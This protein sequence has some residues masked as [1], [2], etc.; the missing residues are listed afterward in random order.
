MKSSQYKQLGKL[1][2]PL[3]KICYF[4]PRFTLRNPIEEGVL[5]AQSKGYEVAIIVYK[6]KE[7]TKWIQ[8][9]GHDEMD[10]LTHKLKLKCQQAVE[11]KY[12]SERYDCT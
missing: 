8:Q 12:K 5:K 10:T 11:T 9:F 3:H 2:L 7:L 1:F 6:I 4:P